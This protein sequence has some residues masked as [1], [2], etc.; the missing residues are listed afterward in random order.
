MMRHV[1]NFVL[2]LEAGVLGAITIALVPAMIFFHLNNF[3][4]PVQIDIRDY[5]IVVAFDMFGILGIVLGWLLL[6][7][8]L[9]KGRDAA[10]RLSVWWWR[11]AYCAAAISITA[12]AFCFYGSPSLVGVLVAAG[13][14]CV[15]TL[16]H[17]SAEVWLRR[18]A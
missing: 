13:V 10:M 11:A 7:C 18:V 16:L 2:L 1:S 4:S 3:L 17:L 8:Y 9:L 15:P 6:L 12:C 14:V 5:A